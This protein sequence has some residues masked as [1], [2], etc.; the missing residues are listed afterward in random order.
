MAL[1]AA[2]SCCAAVD[3]I[4]E[5]A[6][7]NGLA[8]VRPP[9]HH[10]ER[11]RVG[12][13]CLFNNTAIA[14]R[15][16]Q[17]VHGVTR[18]L[19]VDFDVHHGNGTQEIFYS[20][21]N[22]LYISL[23]LYHPFFYPGTGAYS[24]LGR[25]AGRGTTVNVPFPPRVGDAG[26]DE[27]MSTIVIPRARHFHPEIILVS[28][29]FDA[30][31]EDPLAHALVSLRGYARMTRQLIMLAREYC[32]GR[33]LF[34]LEGG[35]RRAALHFGLLNVVHALNDRDEV[36]DPLGPAPKGEEDVTYLLKGIRDLH[37]LK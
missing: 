12:G 34:I 17:A 26:Y 28:A 7:E 30:H 2:G 35:Y 24:E 18:V 4:M 8:V 3:G 23:H 1:L 32:H 16:A 36:L 37:L 11:D 33:V 13:F 14:A 5:G 31:W 20:D 19:I 27:A 29:G 9:G 10:A 22:V 25:G 21:E 6:G 15:H